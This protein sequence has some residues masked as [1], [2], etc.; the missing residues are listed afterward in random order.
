MEQL[1]IDFLERA[2]QDDLLNEIDHTY[3]MNQLLR[4]LKQ[5]TIHPQLAPTTPLPSMDTIME[6]LIKV[7]VDQQVIGDFLH[8][9]QA[10]EAAIMNLLTPLPSAVNLTFWSLYQESPQLATDY[11]YQLSQKNRYIQTKAIAKNIQFPYKGKYGTLDITINLSKPEKDPKKIA[12]ERT[13]SQL[14][15]PASPLTMSNEGYYGRS[16]H[17]ARSNHRIIRLQLGEENWGFQYSPYAYFNEHSIFLTQ[18]VRP[19]KINRRTF[20]NLLEILQQFPHYFVGSNA[21]LPIVGGS[22]LTHDHY[23]AGRHQFP[24]D[25]ARVLKSIRKDGFDGTISILYWPLSVIR[26]S[27]SNKQSL[28]EMA[29]YILEQW[30]GYSDERVSIIAKTN[31]T[32]HNTVTPIARM[33]NGHYELD[34]ALRN[35]RTSEEY[36]DGIFHPHIDVQ[37]IKKENIGL[38]EVM[39]LAILPPRLKQEL[40]EVE[41][42]LLQRPHQMPT[43]HQK[44]AD[45]LK[46]E[47]TLTS[48]NVHEQVLEKVGQIFERVLEDAGVFKQTS[49]GQAAFLRFIDHL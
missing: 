17:P 46:K 18:E 5:E 24:M 31:Q 2:I 15:Y 32:L 30:E 6:E 38:I 34:L 13:T 33:R 14:N 9:K 20:E 4:L 27:S 41:N 11:F 19:M 49:E 28:I 23:Q 26:L 1:L 44:W 40:A 22:I 48:S 21:G 10:L 3:V 37:P 35:N 12:A 43:I 25:R 42:Y 45:E 47:R 29:T 16:D 8:E 39:G 7:A 36:P